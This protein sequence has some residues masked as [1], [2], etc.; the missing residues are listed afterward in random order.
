MQ[1]DL[2]RWLADEPV[3][4]WHEPL[5][6]RFAGGCG[7]T[8]PVA[9]AAAA[10]LIVTVPA[11][12]VALQRERLN[13]QRLGTAKAVSDRRLDQTMVAIEDYYTGVS[14]EVL[15]GQKEF[16][17]LRVRFLEKPRQFYDRLTTELES[18]S[19][20]RGQALLARG[21]Y[22]LGRLLWLLGRHEEAGQQHEAAIKLYRAL[23]AAHPNSA[24]TRTI[25]R[26]ATSIW[27]TC[28]KTW[29]IALARPNLS[30]PRSESF[31][32]W[33]PGTRT[34]QITCTASVRLRRSRCCAEGSTG[35]QRR[36]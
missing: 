3:S 23:V 36:G 18:A 10:I 12:G 31:I 19:D 22:S 4:A 16:Q 17:D 33:S 26:G 2:E 15:L 34:T 1:A 9:A 28:I 20:E 29:E 24:D 5:R 14:Q 6:L 11:L 30:S 25:W 13:A 35:Q 8:V 7:V 32:S 27:A 21:R